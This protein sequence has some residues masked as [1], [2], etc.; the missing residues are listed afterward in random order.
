MVVDIVLP[1]I[2]LE[3]EV[4]KL[5]LFERLRSTFPVQWNIDADPLLKDRYFIKDN[6]GKVTENKEELIYRVATALTNEASQIE[7]FYQMMSSGMFLPNTPTLVNAQRPLGM[8]SACLVL[9]T[10]DSIEEW[11]KTLY[12]HMIMVK[13]GIGT[14]IDLSEIRQKGAMINTTKGQAGGALGFL[15]LINESAK[16]VKQGSVRPSANMGTMR[17][18]HPELE[19]FI[20]SKAA[21]INDRGE[22]EWSE[23]EHFNISI[24]AFDEEFEALFNG[25]DIPIIEPHTKKML[26]YRKGYEILD[27]I[28]KYVWEGGDP[29]LLNLTKANKNN[30]IVNF[31][32]PITDEVFGLKMVTNP[33]GEQWLY[34]FSVCNLGS[35]NLSK[36]TTKR[37][38]DFDTFAIYTEWAIEFLDAVI[39]AN[40]FPIAEIELMSQ[41]LRN[42]GLGIMGWADTLLKL[43]I[44]YDSE[45][46]IE[47]AEQ[48]MGVFKNSA[49]RMSREL[50][51]RNGVAPVFRGSSNDFRNYERTCI[52]PTGSISHIAGVSSGIEPN[53]TF[54]YTRKTSLRDGTE[55]FIVNDVLR[56]QLKG[57]KDYRKILQ[58]I[59]DNGGIIS[60]TI[61][62]KMGIKENYFRT[63]FDVSP[64]WHIRHQAVFQNYVDNAVSKTI[65]VPEHFTKEDI[66]RAYKL[67]WELGCK[68]ITIYRDKSRSY[69]ILNSDKTNNDN[70]NK[71]G[72]SKTLIQQIKNEESNSEESN[73]KENN[74]KERIKSRSEEGSSKEEIPK[75]KI[76]LFKSLNICCDYPNPVQADGCTKCINCGTSYCG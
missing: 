34:A 17:I 36:F 29:G 18:T 26:G 62:Q 7:K 23:L 76:N 24:T 3:K 1:M 15:N 22:K 6:E 44:P 40:R 58:E 72:K 5:S 43:K 48:I 33:C 16:L 10:G 21:K 60:N 55:F 70:G 73:R 35:L 38:F 28:T 30:P 64:E 71:N 53:F 19:D 11:G 27:L 45:E 51:K 46:A 67:S 61:A 41:H 9:P 32:N 68:G 52:A 42:I 39:D 50:G 37:G 65:N 31:I 47:L 25:R 49:D 63:T 75:E 2:E 69:Q 14:G 56:K 59:I 54:A 8:L 20:K 13:A 57:H 12:N 4:E 66:K 74:S